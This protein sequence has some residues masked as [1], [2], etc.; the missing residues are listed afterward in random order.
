[1]TA[2]RRS[3]SRR[4]VRRAVAAAV[5]LVGAAA[6]AG[7]APVAAA[8][9]GTDL[10]LVTLAGPGTAGDTSPLPETM[11]EL[12]MRGQQD[13]V[14]AAVGAPE[15]VYRWTSA[16]NG[17]A[18]R[19][20]RAQADEIAA[21]PGVVA[22]ERDTVRPLA[23]APGRGSATERL[24]PSGRQ[25]GG[26]GVVIGVVDSGLSPDSPAFA[27]VPGLGER[28]ARFR[29]DCSQSADW[30]ASACN[31]KVVG[32]SWFLAG[33]GED[34]VRSASS[35]SPRD[36]DGHGTQVASIAAGNAG[37]AVRVDD[38]EL[39]SY[40]GVAPQARLAVYKACW[41][42][43]DPADDG[44]STADLVSAVDRA[45]HDRVDVLNL[46]VGGSPGFDV[47]ERALLGAAEED[48]VVVAAAGNDG[49]RA[50]ASHPSPWVTTVGGTT[51]P[52]RRGSVALG[53][54]GPVV[55]GLMASP[56]DVGP[57]RLVVGADVS[58]PGARIDDARVCAP[59]SL[60]A[61]RVTGAVVLCDR[62]RVGRVDKSAA[63]ERADGVGMVLANVRRQ[64][65]DTDLHSVPTVHLD[66]ADG[67][68]VRTWSRSHPLARV[69]LTSLGTDRAASQVLA[70]SG[71]GDPAGAVVK[72]DVVAPATGVLGAVPSDVR[73]TRWAFASGTSAAT[74]IT[75]GTAALLVDRRGWSATA[76]RSALATSAAPVR[77]TS[78][79][80]AGAGRVRAER[81]LRPGL[82]YLTDPADYRAFIDG[83][84]AGRDP[85]QVLNLPSVLLGAEES[86]TRRTI[87]N[88]GGRAL[89][90][91]SSA[92]G[93]THHRAVVTPAAVRLDPGESAR[94]TL[95]LTARPG[96]PRGDDG[97][98]VWRG[99]D[100]TRAS[101]PVVVS[102]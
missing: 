70:W 67:D 52:D 24:V 9:D 29:G 53:G 7:A 98:V 30:R 43:P 4:A 5:A 25:R 78:P 32:G 50:F 94:F 22:T 3:R 11:L 95:T 72:P 42:A 37:V 47:L 49:E 45:T 91:S 40:A 20:T 39:G 77:G 31:G 2:A 46:S 13:A 75:S 60:D 54:G 27:S 83:R 74:A 71:S 85:E 96:A 63:V 61:A 28:P 15:P 81:A 69:T 66:R 79:L 14:L 38:D 68:A 97:T 57:A 12:S 44:C 58:A 36:D 17:V 1:M 18:V 8:Q 16:L 41:T 102:R 80:R 34:A 100:G 26:A 62:G 59:G 65:L 55:E 86:R 6:L 93:F 90:F 51:G 33:F 19:L 99:G 56:R 88:V 10:W 48:V 76:V 35:L 82:V 87:T 84:L 89:Y 92:R 23:A 73:G 101:I 21:Q 64:S